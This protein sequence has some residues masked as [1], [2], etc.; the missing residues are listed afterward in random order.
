MR[1]QA[2]FKS[3]QAG[4]NFCQKLWDNMMICTAEAGC[5]AGMYPSTIQEVASVI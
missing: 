2:S 4:L 5:T 1:L 3:Q